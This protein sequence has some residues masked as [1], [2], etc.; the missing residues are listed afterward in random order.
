MDLYSNR[1]GLDFTEWCGRVDRIVHDAGHDL[2]V[3]RQTEFNW[4][5]RFVADEK[6]EIAARALID[7]LIAH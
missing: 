6:P 7:V 1:S 2:G 3:A 4:A 5:D